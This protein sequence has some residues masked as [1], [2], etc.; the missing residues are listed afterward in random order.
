M[1]LNLFPKDLLVELDAAGQPHTTS[2]AV[3]QA[4]SKNHQHV[5]R[6]IQKIVNALGEIKISEL[7]AIAEE[8]HFIPDVSGQSNFGQSSYQNAQNKTQPMYRLNRNG[9]MLLVMGYTGKKALLVKLR[10]L[11]AFDTMEELLSERYASYENAFRTLRPRLAIVAE[12]PDLSRTEL[13]QLTGHK[14]P[15]SITS[16][17]K[18]CRELGLLQN[19][20]T[21]TT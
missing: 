21:I 3:A 7:E 10:F 9:F 1:N 19:C 5:M 17:R 20:Q 16:S 12:H 13:Q 15:S 2:L 14:S 6:D 8:N 11:A 4:F 18:R